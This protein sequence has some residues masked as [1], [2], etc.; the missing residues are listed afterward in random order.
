MKVIIDTSSLLSLVRY[1]LPFDKY[2]K[3]VNYFMKEI[4]NGNI[5]IIDKVLEQSTYI[6]KGLI[7][8]K[9]TFLTDK[10]FLYDNI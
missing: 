7:L 10:N 3:L 4:E 8:N 6:S 9:L 2:S 1:Y 5:I